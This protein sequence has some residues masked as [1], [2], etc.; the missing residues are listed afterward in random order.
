MKKVITLQN[1]SRLNEKQFINYFEKKVFYTIRKFNLFEGIEQRPQVH[2][3][4]T[5]KKINNAVLSQECLDE[6]SLQILQAMMKNKGKQKLASLLP[7][8]KN[9]I[10]PFYLMS[11]EEMILY[12]KI[13]LR[14]KLSK[15]YR[16]C[17]TKFQ[18]LEDKKHNNPVNNMHLKQSAKENLKLSPNNLHLIAFLN[19]LEKQQRNVKNSIVSSLLKMENLI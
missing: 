6:I 3:L 14:G 5:L 15:E 19:E 18:K 13:K 7:K 9:V 17:F 1:G 11:K 4:F 8:H 2:E 10:R 12:M 16:D